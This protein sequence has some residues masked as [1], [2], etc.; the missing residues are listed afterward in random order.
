MRSLALFR[1]NSSSGDPD[2][3]FCGKVNSTESGDVHF[4]LL[5]TNG[6]PS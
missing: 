2:A 5:Q 6:L 4:E 3:G 1:T